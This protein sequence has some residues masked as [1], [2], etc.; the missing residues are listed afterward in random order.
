MD[1]SDRYELAWGT[2]RQKY[3]KE[4]EGFIEQAVIEVVADEAEELEKAMRVI[5][6]LD[7]WKVE[8]IEQAVEEYASG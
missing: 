6:L 4:K 1:G 7:D 2:G 3:D 8:E 5:E